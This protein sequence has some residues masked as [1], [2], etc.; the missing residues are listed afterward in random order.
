MFEIIITTDIYTHLIKTHET[1]RLLEHIYGML[2]QM[3]RIVYLLRVQHGVLVQSTIM[4][5]NE[6]QISKRG[7]GECILGICYIIGVLLC[8]AHHNQ[9]NVTSTL[10]RCCTCVHRNVR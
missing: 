3:N 5:L 7:Y 8:F 2:R 9:R 10:L 4:R 6:G 1:V